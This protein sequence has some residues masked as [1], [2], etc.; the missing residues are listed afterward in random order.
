MLMPPEPSG[1]RAYRRIVGWEL[2]QTKNTGLMPSGKG[3][4]H[5]SGRT[6]HVDPRYHARWLPDCSKPEVIRC[7]LTA[8]SNGKSA[9]RQEIKHWRD[10]CLSRAMHQGS[11]SSPA[12]SPVQTT[13]VSLDSLRCWTV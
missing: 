3:A 4:A 7:R 11:R 10:G 9:S 1:E 6:W 13:A 5:R 12:I 2:S 8:I